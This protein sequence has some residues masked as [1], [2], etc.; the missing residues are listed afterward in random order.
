MIIKLEKVLIEPKIEVRIHKEDVDCPFAVWINDR[1]C[2]WMTKQEAH[3]LM[4][5]LASAEEDLE[6]RNEGLPKM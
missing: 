4:A 5:Q 1:L 3:H 6:R 2:L